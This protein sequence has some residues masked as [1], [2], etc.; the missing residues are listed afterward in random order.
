MSVAATEVVLLGKLGKNEVCGW[1]AG[2]RWK[3]RANAG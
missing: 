2:A 3:L 1:A